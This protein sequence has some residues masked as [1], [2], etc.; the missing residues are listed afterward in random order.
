MHR[1]FIQCDMFCLSWQCQRHQMILA[2]GQR[3]GF[4]IGDG[5]G[6]GKGRQVSDVVRSADSPLV[7]PLC[8][9]PRVYWVWQIPGVS[10]GAAHFAQS[11][12]LA[13][14]FLPRV[15]WVWQIPGVSLGA[16]HIS[17]ALTWMGSRDSTVV[18]HR[19]HDWFF[20][21]FLNLKQEWLLAF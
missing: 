14:S 21:L 17:W 8:S 19:I 11:C 2:N 1:I 6:V 13:S 16:A 5:A 9:Y 18:E 15:Y 3:A 20:C 7:W 4:F 10:L 12:G